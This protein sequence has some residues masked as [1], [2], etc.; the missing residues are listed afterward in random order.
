MFDE[1]YEGAK[2]CNNV[3]S[4]RSYADKADALKLR[5]LTEMDH[6]DAKLAQQKAVEQAKRQAE[7]ARKNGAPA[8]TE[9]VEP[10]VQPKIRKVKN[11]SIKKMTGTA[12]WRLESAEDV[13]KYIDELKQTLITQLDGDTIVNVEF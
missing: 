4:L 8:T 1:I 3:S 2:S 11:V 7:E 12:S 10:I 6:L 5:L 9:S 13:E